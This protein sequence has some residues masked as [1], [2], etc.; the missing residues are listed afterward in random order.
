[1]PDE[2]KDSLVLAG[3]RLQAQMA[4]EGEERKKKREEKIRIEG[5]AAQKLQREEERK[6]RDLFEKEKIEQERK[7][8][9]IREATV[10]KETSEQLKKQV[11]EIKGGGDGLKTIRT[12]K[13][14]RDNLV[15]AQG[16]SVIGI[17]IKEEEKKAEIRENT[18]VSS[19]TNLI[20]LATSIFLILLGL[21]TGFYA[22]ERYTKESAGVTSPET[23]HRQ[24]ILSSDAGVAF[25]VSQ[26]TVNDLTAKIKNEVRNPP[27]LRLGSVEGLSFYKKDSAGARTG[28]TASEFLLSLGSEAP[29]SFLRTLDSEFMFGIL[30][31]AENAAFIIL[32]TESYDKGWAGLLDWDNKTLA[33]DLYQILTALKPDEDLLTEKF[34]DLIIKNIDTRVLKDKGGVIRIVYG[35]LDGEK[36]IAIAGSKQAFI[37]A[38]DRFSILRPV[39]R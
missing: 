23:I 7:E 24:S 39:T 28:V 14:D 32:R 9:E 30:S 20:I 3:K 27:D 37:E 8:Q 25:D 12:L 19:G 35:F 36:T 2:I 31:S 4:M 34:E 26:I 6:R 21:G 13:D 38:L 17:A 33:R 22:Y 15:R 18:S 11:E 5:E 10:K 1:M 16:L 29:G